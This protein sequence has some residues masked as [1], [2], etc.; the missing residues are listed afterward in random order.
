MGRE[1]DGL[2][3]FDRIIVAA[4]RVRVAVAAVVV[5]FLFFYLHRIPI[6]CDTRYG[7]Q[8][9][10]RMY[11]AQG[12][13]KKTSFPFIRHTPRPTVHTKANMCILVEH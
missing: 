10:Q 11:A 9:A 7:R 13:R 1:L 2:H 4:V 6:S 12:R 8:K 5:A 3:F